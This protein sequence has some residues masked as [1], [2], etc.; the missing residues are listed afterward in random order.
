VGYQGIS[1]DITEKVK[2]QQELTEYREKLEL[3]NKELRESEARY[4]ELFE[5]AQDIMYVVDNERNFLEI[6]KAGCQTLGC[7]KEDIIGNNFAKWMTPESLKIAD[8]RRK[9]Y[10][11]GEVLNVPDILE[12]VSKNGE[13]RWIEVKVRII[14]GNN[15]TKEIHGIGRDITENVR[16]KQ[17]LKKSNKQRKLLC[18]LIEGTRGGKTRALILKHLTGKSYN[19]HQLTKALN[20][21]YKTIRHHL[22]VLIKNGIITKDDDSGNTLY[23]IPKTMEMT[24]HDIRQELQ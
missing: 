1:R 15:A 13:H 20:M 24:L 5:N 2:M 10:V 7:E 3:S 14:K 17:E 19:A 4:R 16:L 6:N 8:D 22:D 21:Y 12:L 11:S 18:H 23:L 9:K